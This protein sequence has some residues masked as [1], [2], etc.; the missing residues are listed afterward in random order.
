MLQTKIFFGYMEMG[1]FW[2]ICLFG[3]RN[4]YQTS[5]RPLADLEKTR[6]NL[7][8]T[9]PSYLRFC[10]NLLNSSR[11]K[12][13]RNLLKT[14]PK[15]HKTF[16]TTHLVTLLRFLG[17]SFWFLLSCFSLSLEDVMDSP[18]PC[19]QLIFF[20]GGGGLL[21]WFRVRSPR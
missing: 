4:V 13:F 18:A 7:F 2:P 5:S 3:A 21:A 15:P 17:L 8:K 12:T 20:F 16:A 11:N 1:R 14:S 9:L 10:Q 19:L 6:Q